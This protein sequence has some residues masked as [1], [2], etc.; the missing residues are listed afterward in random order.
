M[1]AGTRPRRTWPFSSAGTGKVL[2]RVPGNAVQ[3]SYAVTGD[4]HRFLVGKP[5][6]EGVAEPITVVLNWLAKLKG[7][8]Q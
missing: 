3:R 2:F 8:V 7:R 6:D 5:V 1:R 4:G